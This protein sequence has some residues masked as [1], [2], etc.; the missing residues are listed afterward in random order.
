MDA[1][2][3]ADREADEI[4]DLVEQVVQYPASRPPE[5]RLY[6]N[7]HISVHPI[8]TDAAERLEHAG[9]EEEVI[10]EWVITESREMSRE[11]TPP[12]QFFF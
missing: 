5:T 9:Q 8:A 7:M 6:P 2:E 12:D 11:V 3:K 1:E 10:S 4:V